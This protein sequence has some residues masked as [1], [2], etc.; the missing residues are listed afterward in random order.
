MGA[1]AL[2]LQFTIL[3]LNG[4][5]QR[6]EGRILLLLGKLAD[7]DLEETNALRRTVTDLLEQKTQLRLAKSYSVKEPTD[8]AQ[9]AMLKT[10]HCLERRRARL[11][12]II[13]LLFMAM[14]VLL[15]LLLFKIFQQE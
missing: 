5:K 7:K 8:P 3:R 11:D 4:E 15:T 1:L 9:R 2:V 6:Y 14:S 12:W 13:V 10:I